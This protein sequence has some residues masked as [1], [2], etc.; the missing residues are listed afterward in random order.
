MKF[1]SD[2][3][4]RLVRR[5]FRRRAAGDHAGTP[6]PTSIK[7]LPGDGS[8][9]DQAQANRN[10][11]IRAVDSSAMPRVRRYGDEA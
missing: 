5:G 4:V 7:G 2:V 9:L 11:Q 3:V 1:L 6:D 10:D 8:L